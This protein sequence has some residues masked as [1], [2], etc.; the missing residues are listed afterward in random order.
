VVI[1][2]RLMNSNNLANRLRTVAIAL[3][4]KARI[5]MLRFYI[6]NNYSPSEIAR[7]MCY[8]TKDVRSKIQHTLRIVDVD[9]IKNDAIYKKLMSLEDV[10]D[11]CHLKCKLCGKRKFYEEMLK[12]LLTS[13]DGYV[14]LK[15]NEVLGV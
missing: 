7:I 15:L 1:R 4:D 2:L 13:H 5:E 11:T 10:Y 14:H 3:F 9:M 12:H 6:V 8:E